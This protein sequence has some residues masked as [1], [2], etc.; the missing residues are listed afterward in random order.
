MTYKSMAK[1]RISGGNRINNLAV[2]T[3]FQAMVISL[4]ESTS[5]FGSDEKSSVTKAV[6]EL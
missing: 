3:E 5:A 4:F 1:I 2:T 6:A